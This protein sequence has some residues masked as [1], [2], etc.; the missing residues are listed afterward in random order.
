MQTENHKV[1]LEESVHPHHKNHDI[2]K[3]VRDATE[4]GIVVPSI[5]KKGIED[6]GYTIVE[7]KA[8][9]AQYGFKSTKLLK[10]VLVVKDDKIV[11]MGMAGDHKEA[12]LA[13]MLGWFRENPSD[14]F[15]EKMAAGVGVGVTIAPENNAG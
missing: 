12:L 14:D 5:L 13:A 9:L 10:R 3:A 4:V 8:S 7:D 2:A 6:A 15:K 11:A 1:L